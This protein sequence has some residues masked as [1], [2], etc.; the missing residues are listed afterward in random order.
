MSI[1]FQRR[2]GELETLIKQRKA[3]Q[4]VNFEW[5]RKN[6]EK[7]DENRLEEIANLDFFEL[8]DALQSGKCLPVETLLAFQRKALKSHATTNCICMFIEESLTIAE[9]LEQNLKDADYCKPPLFGIP[10]SIKECIRVKFMDSTQGCAQH[11]YKPSREHAASVDQLIRLGAVPFVHTNVPQALLSFGCSNPIYGSTS[12]PC[13]SSRVPGGSSGGEAAL[14]AAGGSVLGIGT[15]VGGSVRTPATFCGLAAF[16]SSS[17][18][19]S[20]LG[21]VSSIPGR[22]LL[23]TVEGPIA[24]TIDACVEYLRLKWNDSELSRRDFYVPP[25]NFREHLYDSDEPLRIG[26]YTFDGYQTAPAAYRRAVLDAVGVLRELGHHL[27]EFCVP[28]AAHA[29]NIFCAAATSDG[30]VFLNELLSNDIVPPECYVG[31]PVTRLPYFIQRIL[32]KYLPDERVK[33][34]LRELPHNSEEMREMHEKIE[35]Y[36]HEFVNAMRKQKL[37][38]IVCPAFGTLAP[39]HGIPNQM[40]SA[41]SYTSLFNLVDFAAGTIPITRVSANDESVDEATMPC[42][43]RWN[44]LIRRESTGCRG[45]PISVQIAAPPFREEICLRI[46]RQIQNKIG[47]ARN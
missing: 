40:I 41:T 29:F 4:I 44:Q 27:E 37:D 43:D 17:R 11:L 6:F 26:Y 13:D 32:R 31:P 16:K 25:V 14:I 24:P 1:S 10:I 34:V 5:A 7:L 19:G 46:L 45:M 20:Q 3:E 15:D 9:G 18:R 22:Q 2:R 36:R 23:V 33:G 47:I 42:D 38:A 8:R 30:G 28:R 35:D 39:H 12:N 21:T